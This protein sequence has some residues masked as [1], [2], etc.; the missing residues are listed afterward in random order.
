MQ[1]LDLSVTYEGG[2]CS[3]W[4]R[5]ET[6]PKIG[7]ILEAEIENQMRK[8]KVDYVSTAGLVRGSMRVPVRG[9][10]IEAHK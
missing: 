10:V 7:D 6:I 9:H 8:V 1:R 2:E 4:I 5:C 3:T